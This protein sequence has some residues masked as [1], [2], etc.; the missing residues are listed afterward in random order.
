MR[1][2]PDKKIKASFLSKKLE[3]NGKGQK[4]KLQL[5]WG[6]EICPDAQH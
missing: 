1:M 3:K 6:R 4:R 2:I 5:M